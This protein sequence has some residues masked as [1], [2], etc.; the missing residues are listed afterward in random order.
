MRTSD[1]LDAL[2]AHHNKTSDYQIAKLTGFSTQSV[3]RYRLNKTTFDETASIHVAKLLKIEPA[4][5]LADMNA[6]RSKTPEARKVW[7]NLHDRLTSTA[8]AVL[9]G[10]A[11]VMVSVPAPVYAGA[12]SAAMYIM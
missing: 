12:E 2:K 3:S 9:L 7:E 6:I 1:Y 5:V 8:A 10:F 11:V 4:I